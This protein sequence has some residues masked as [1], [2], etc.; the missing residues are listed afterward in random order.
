MTKFTKSKF[1]PPAE[2]AEPEGVVFFGGQ[3]TPEWLLDAYSHGIFPWP[4]FPETEVMVWWSPDPRAIFELD[5]LRITRRLWRTCRNGRFNVTLNRDFPSVIE[6]CATAGDRLNNT[7]ITP[8]IIAAYRKLHE[9]GQAHSIEVWQHNDLVG[10]IYGVVLGGLFAAESMFHYERDASKVALVHLIHQL[11]VRGFQLFDIQQLTPHSESMG[12]VEIPRNTYLE[13][14]RAAL[15]QPT[16][17]G[18]E[19]VSLPA[20][21]EEI[22]SLEVKE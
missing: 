5:G 21:K 1:F 6:S 12:A 2:L 16:T 17:L 3:L 9:N 7:W 11:R 13:R 10:G 22:S 8:R 14:L 20:S 15:E 18:Q 19:L 4:I